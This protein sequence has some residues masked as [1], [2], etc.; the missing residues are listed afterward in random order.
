MCGAGREHHLDDWEELK[1]EVC[2]PR[3]GQQRRE[4]AQARCGI[5]QHV[6]QLHQTRQAR[7]WP[8]VSL[9]S[10]NHVLSVGESG[11]ILRAKGTRLRG[12]LWLWSCAAGLQRVDEGGDAP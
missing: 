6:V 11:C 2:I 12:M 1:S 5:C 9:R 7:L 8:I 4:D 10:T 3:K